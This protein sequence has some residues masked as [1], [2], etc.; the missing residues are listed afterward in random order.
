MPTHVW[1][2]TTYMNHRQIEAFLMPCNTAQLEGDILR[3][4]HCHALG[5]RCGEAP[6]DLPTA[7]R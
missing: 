5:H 2:P 1:I 4:T 7:E 6:K 3:P